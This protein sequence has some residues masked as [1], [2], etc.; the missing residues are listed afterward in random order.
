MQKSM[1]VKITIN[2]LNPCKVSWITIVLRFHMDNS[3]GIFPSSIW[4][5]KILPNNH[6]SLQNL[7]R[8]L[9]GKF[10]RS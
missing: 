9:I 4:K 5:T 8:N 10:A 6:E 1:I 2:Y 3:A 7:R